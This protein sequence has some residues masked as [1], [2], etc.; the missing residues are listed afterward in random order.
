KPLEKPCTPGV[1]TRQ[2]VAEVPVGGSVPEFEQKPVT[3]A[4]QEGKNAIFRAVVRGDPSPQVHWHCSKGALSNSSKYQ[5][6]SPGAEEHTLQISR[7]TGEDTDLYRCTAANTYGEAV[8]SA[9]LTVIEVGFRKNWKRPKEPQAA[10]GASRAPDLLVL[11]PRVPP[12]APEKKMD[13]EQVWQLLMAA[14]RK[15]YEQICRRYGIVDFR[16]MLRRLRKIRWEQEDEVAQ[17]VNAVSNLRHIKVTKEGVATFDLELDLKDPESKVYLYKDGEMITCGSDEQTRHC[18][19]RLGKRYHFR[20]RDLRPEDA[21]VYQVKV[22]G[23]EVFATELEAAAV[24][25]RV[26]VPLATARCEEQGDA[27]FGCTLSSP[28]PSAAWYFQ[29]RPLRPSPRYE[30]SVSPD[31][32]THRLVVRGAALSDVGLYSLGTG[33]HASSAWLLVEGECCT[34]TFPPPPKPARRARTPGEGAPLGGGSGSLQHPQGWRAGRRGAGSTGR[35][36]SES[37]GSWGAGCTAGPGRALDGSGV[38]R[39]RGSWPPGPADA[40]GVTHAWGPDLESQGLGQGRAGGGHPPAG[41]RASSSPQ[42]KGSTL[43]GTRVG[44]G[45]SREPGRGSGEEP[46]ASPGPWVPASKGPSPR[47]GRSRGPGS[48][49]VLDGGTSTSRGNGVPPKPGDS[50]HEGAWEDLDGPFGSKGLGDEPGD[51][52][53]LGSQRGKGHRGR[54]GLRGAEK[55]QTPGLRTPQES[56]GWG[57][58]P[59]RSDRRPGPPRDQLGDQRQTPAARRVGA[60]EAR[61]AGQPAGGSGGALEEA[62]SQGQSPLHPSHPGGRRGSPADRRG[63]PPVTAPRA[64]QMRKH[65]GG[66]PPCSRVPSPATWGRAPGPGMESRRQKLEEPL[67]VKAG[68]PVTV[69]M[70]F[71]SRLPVGL[72]GGRTGPRRWAAAAGGLGALG[73]SFAGL[74]PASASRK[75]RGQSQPPQG[76]LVLQARQWAGVCLGW[77]APQDEGGRAV[78]RYEVQGRQVGRSWPLSYAVC[79]HAGRERWGAGEA[80]VPEEALL[81]PEALPGPPST[82]A[83]LSA[84]GTGIALTWTAP[85]GPGS[86]HITG[87][88]GE[89]HQQ[90]SSS[91]AAVK[92]Q[93]VPGPPGPARDRQVTDTSSTSISLSRARPDARAGHE[94][95]GYVVELCGPDS[96]RWRPGHPGTVPVTAFTAKGPRLHESYLVRVTAV[97]DGGPSPPMALDTMVQAVPRTASPKFLTGS[98]TRDSLTV[99]AG[100]TV[101]VPVPFVVSIPNAASPLPEVTWLKD[102][103]PLPKSSVTATEHGLIQLLVPAASLSDSSRYTVVLR[104]PRGQEAAYNFLLRVAGEAAGTGPHRAGQ[105]EASWAGLAA[106]PSCPTAGCAR[107]HRQPFLCAPGGSAGPAEGVAASRFTCCLR[108]LG[109]ASPGPL[110]ALGDHPESPPHSSAPQEPGLGGRGRSRSSWVF[111]SMLLGPQMRLPL[112]PPAGNPRPPGPIRLQENVPGT[113]TAEWA[114]S[115][116]EAAGVLLHYAVLTRS[117][118]HRPWR[119]AADRVHT[120]RFTLPGVLPGREYHFRVVAKTELGTSAPADTSRPWCVPRRGTSS[121]RC[122]VPGPALPTLASLCLPTDKLSARAPRYWE[123]DLSRKPRFLVGLRAHLLPR[124]CQCC[125]SCAV[126]GW[127]RPH[128]TWFK[129]GQ[130]LAGDPEAYSTDVL[131]VCSLVIPSVAPKDSSEYKAVAENKLGQAVSTATLIVTGKGPGRGREGEPHRATCSRGAPGGPPA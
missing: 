63:A 91:W 77:R 59:G 23:A 28:C 7:L 58:E 16:G 124:G 36:E 30:V 128:V 46:G 95:Q 53:G 81:A 38:L 14:D 13:S 86:A 35:A 106:G 17:F 129:N 70:P 2:L 67:L 116:D 48:S 27:A 79:V 84:S 104:G 26:V 101:R 4:L 34:P 92:Q 24:P 110:A 44:P 103:L 42:E 22:E 107:L 1:S 41:S 69:K 29:H 3:L 8:C 112:P 43:R 68:Q 82:P 65:S 31:G 49:G 127:P 117:S 97:N 89:K 76:P 122:P 10:P 51:T 93:P 118:R 20:I 39:E 88:L 126:G 25:P 57:V 37:P 32:L 114:P 80:L 9:R 119:E 60:A 12:P 96:V 11:L 33:L 121:F 6:S 108:H 125:M 62:P 123:P 73:D 94:A 15:D 115:P 52:R 113:V 83:T 19:R 98:S 90:G 5:I 21:G 109:T 130:S 61:G 99:R 18:L 74:G 105:T 55:E 66:S 78:E 100:D 71:Q 120:N 131:G 50:G 45:G 111:L 64:W 54:T 47:R 72:F 75:D 87:C 56:G 40:P 85:R 102:G